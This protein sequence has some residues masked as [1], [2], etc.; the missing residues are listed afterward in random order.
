MNDLIES[1][2]I[3]SKYFD[4]TNAYPTHCGPDI[5]A[6]RV[7]DNPDGITSVDRARLEQLSWHFNDEYECWCSYRFGSC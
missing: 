6:L 3:F 4:A 5:L 1:L 7:A 2:Q